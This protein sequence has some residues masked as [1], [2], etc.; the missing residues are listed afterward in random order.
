MTSRDN[1]RKRNYCIN[2]GKHGHIY[3]HCREPI[4]S[5]GIINIKID[6]IDEKN[7]K[8]VNLVKANLK[9]NLSLLKESPKGIN[10]KN[11]AVDTQTFCLYKNNIKFLMIQRK[12][13]LGYLEFMRGRYKIENNDGII[14][15]FQQMTEYEISNIGKKTF[16][17]L[18]VDLWKNKNFS[19]DTEYKISKEKFMKLKRKEDGLGLDFYINEVTPNFTHTEWGFP[20][21][22][23]GRDQ[24]T[25]LACGI[26]E[27]KEETGLTSKDIDILDNDNYVVEELFGTNGIPYRHIYYLSTS[28]KEPKINDNNEIGN[29]KWFTHQDSREVIRPYHTDRKKLLDEIYIGLINNIIQVRREL[30]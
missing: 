14:F 9:N 3:K 25:N 5:I 1:K 23:R 13:S 11:L 7:D 30:L 8:I 26:R 4:T 2:C 10:Y 6:S 18:W 19:H 12:H 20:K 15:L 29:V 24:E 16:D 28:S 21:G 27:F 17:Y 22:R